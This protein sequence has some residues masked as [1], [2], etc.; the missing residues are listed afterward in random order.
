[1]RRSI[2]V[3]TLLTAVTG[4]ANFQPS[5]VGPARTGLQ[6]LNLGWERHFSV[7]WE[8]G[9]HGNS[10]VVSGY[11]TNTS[12]Y[13][14]AN[15][16][17]LVEALDAGGQVVEQRVGYLPGELR[18]GGRLYF[19]MPIASAATYRVRVFSY[20]RMEAGLMT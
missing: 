1:M 2:L 11:V 3:I 17:V 10:Q 14:L 7:T 6:P 12:P 20:D 15:V 16:R 4:C 9:Q 8:S 19:E 5:Y 13:D 18:G